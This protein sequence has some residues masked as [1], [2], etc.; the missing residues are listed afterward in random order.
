[1]HRQPPEL[2]GAEEPVFR[3]S[4]NG[5]EIPVQTFIGAKLLSS[6]LAFLAAV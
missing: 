6:Q 5:G 2:I 4:I 1:M 3:Y